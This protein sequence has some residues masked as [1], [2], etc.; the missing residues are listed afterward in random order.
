MLLYTLPLL[1]IFMC[2]IPFLFPFLIK[3]M[4]TIISY[5]EQRNHP[6]TCG[7]ISMIVCDFLYILISIFYTQELILGIYFTFN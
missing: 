5:L 1:R 4:Q 2:V 7:D 3:K 6:G